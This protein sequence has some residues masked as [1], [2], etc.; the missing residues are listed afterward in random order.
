MLSR[1]RM[2]VPGTMICVAIL[3]IA[4]LTLRGGMLVVWKGAFHFMDDFDGNGSRQKLH[5]HVKRNMIMIMHSDDMVQA[6]DRP[7]LNSVSIP[8]LTSETISLP[9]ISRSTCD[10]ESIPKCWQREHSPG[11]G[12]HSNRSAYAPSH[13]AHSMRN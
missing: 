4:P 8:D 9:N 10:L 6:A 12:K 7:V 2:S 5:Q 13:L 11:R 1:L 3:S